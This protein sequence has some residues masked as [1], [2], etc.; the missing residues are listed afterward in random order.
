MKYETP[1]I[2]ELSPA[3]ASIQSAKGEP[4]C[5]FNQDASP[6]YQDWE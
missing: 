4:D 5:D 6:A 2:V 1:E 3:I